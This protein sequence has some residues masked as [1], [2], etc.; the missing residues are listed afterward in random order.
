MTAK[1]FYYKFLQHLESELPYYSTYNDG[2]YFSIRQNSDNKKFYSFLKNGEIV[3][4]NLITRIDDNVKID[5]LTGD[6]FEIY[7]PTKMHR[8]CFITNYKLSTQDTLYKLFRTIKV[9]I[10]N[11][12]KFNDELHDEG[13]ITRITFSNGD[14]VNVVIKAAKDIERENIHR[15][16]LSYP[17]IPNVKYVDKDATLV[18]IIYSDT[19]EELSFSEIHNTVSMLA[20]YTKMALK[21]SEFIDLEIEPD[22]Y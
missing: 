11:V 4:R 14:R 16:A 1:Y 20:K 6:D 15:E 3:R 22:F 17:T 18:A 7:S 19:E 2:R 5:E 9:G 12:D 21:E 8:V 10:I 13:N